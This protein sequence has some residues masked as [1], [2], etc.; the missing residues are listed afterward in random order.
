MSSP[1]SVRR[2]RSGFLWRQLVTV[3]T[4]VGVIAAMIVIAQT[5]RG[6]AE[7][8]QHVQV[9]VERVRGASEEMNVFIW[10][11]MGGTWTRSGPGWINQAQ[12]A[13]RG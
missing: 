13:Q 6:E 8:H 5:A 10:L 11:G 1:L 4:A 9:L 3:L 2:P 7:R 12:L